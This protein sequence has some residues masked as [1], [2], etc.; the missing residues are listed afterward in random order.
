[1]CGPYAPDRDTLYAALGVACRAPSLH[2]TQPWRWHLADGFLHLHAEPARMLPATDPAG[3]Q[4]VISCGAA[5]QHATVGFAALGWQLRI[6]RLPDAAEPDRLARIE[7]VPGDVIRAREV[8]LATAAVQR[9][10]DRR[11][12]QPGALPE[13]TLRDLVV[14]A[15][16]HRAELLILPAQV[17]ADLLVSSRLADLEHDTDEDYRLELADWTGAV[18]GAEGVPA[19]ALL[20]P[21]ATRRVQVARDFHRGELRPQAGHQP[22]GATMTV[23]RTP[24]DDRVSWLRA[25]EALGAVL[26]EATSA[27]LAS[28]AV[29]HLTEIAESR[30]VLERAVLGFGA[31]SG[32]P[33]VVIRLGRVTA[34][35]TGPRSPRRPLR[36]AVDGW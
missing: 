11:P 26:L 20:A 9:R 15:H 34:A 14:A 17:A 29:T 22:D 33:Q 27:G 5:L 13:P 30:S 10:T 6:D 25:G 24:V 19:T 2:N 23:L 35:L 31:G 3:R 36:D 16:R 12:Y 18:A 32:H 7:L 4:M 1:M 21:P 28:C 8:A